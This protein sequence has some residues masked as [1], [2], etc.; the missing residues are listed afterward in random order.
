M[1]FIQCVGGYYIFLQMCAYS[2]INVLLFVTPSL[3]MGNLRQEYWS[4]LLCPSPGDLPKPGM[5]LM[6]PKGHVDS[7][8]TET[9]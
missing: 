9:Q 7:L 5:E 3:S 4:G 1:C 6:S 2:L 8:V